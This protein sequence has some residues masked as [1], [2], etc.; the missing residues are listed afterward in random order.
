MNVNDVRYQNQG[1]HVVLAL[2]TVTNGKFKVL[3]IKGKMN[4]LKTNGFWLAVVPTTPKLA[5]KQ[6]NVNFW[7]TRIT[8]VDF[9]MFNVF[10]NP[11]RSPLKRMIA[12]GYFGVS[13]SSIIE[14]FKQTEK[15]SDAEWFEIDKV[16]EL[17]YDH[18]EILDEAIEHLKNSIFKTNIM[19]KLYPNYFTLP[20]LQGTYETIL[21][22]S[23]DR[24]NFRKKLLNE[25]LIVETNKTIKRGNSKPSKLYKFS[26]VSTTFNFYK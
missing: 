19:R 8:D 24:R 1:L 3:L 17:G 4:H 26:D 10:T 23:L 9:Q 15:A 7:K 25:G 16:P 13:D 11:N 14:K 22:V 5:S 6:W 20:E 21:Q 12:I 18:K 2:F